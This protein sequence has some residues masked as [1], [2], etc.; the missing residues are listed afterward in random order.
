MLEQNII[1]YIHITY[2]GVTV[3]NDGPTF[4]G[5]YFIDLCYSSSNNTG[6]DT[7]VIQTGPKGLIGASLL[8]G[9]L[10]DLSNKPDYPMKTTE[11]LYL[12]LASMLHKHATMV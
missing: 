6:N 1:D 12:W 11:E 10:D 2:P 4:G 5:Y 9:T 7:I 3:S 8:S